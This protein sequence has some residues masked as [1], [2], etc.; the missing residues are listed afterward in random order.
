MHCFPV[1]DRAWLTEDQ[2][3]SSIALAQAASGPG[4]LVVAVPCWTVGMYAAGGPWAMAQAT[5][6][7]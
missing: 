1:A 5:A 7:A 2:F 4:V 3:S 6:S